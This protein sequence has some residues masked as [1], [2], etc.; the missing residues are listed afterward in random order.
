MSNEQLSDWTYCTLRVATQDNES[1]ALHEIDI[2]ESDMEDPD[3]DSPLSFYSGIPIPD[4]LVENKDEDSE[5][6]KARNIAST[7]Y[8]SMFEYTKNHWGTPYDAVDSV[9]HYVD[10]NTPNEMLEYQFRTIDGHPLPW[11]KEISANFPLLV[12]EITCQN[13]L[14]LFDS[15]DAI[16][17]NGQQVS[18]QTHKKGKN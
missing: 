2:F 17:I 10:R 5:E 13:E 7:G 11:L 1:D 18:F 4:I 15:F 3:D 9:L 12:F 14:D 16:Y 8:S 6:S